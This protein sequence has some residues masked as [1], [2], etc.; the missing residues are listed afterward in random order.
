MVGAASAGSSAA[1]AW[2][3]VVGL[4]TTLSAAIVGA[5]IQRQIG[6]RRNAHEATLAAQA[7]AH[8]LTAEHARRIF[9]QRARTYI[10]LVRYAQAELTRLNS[11]LE[12]EMT[13]L[14]AQHHEGGMEM[15]EG[16]IGELWA[17][18]QVFGTEPVRQ[19]QTKMIE[20]RSDA[21]FALQAFRLSKRANPRALTIPD[22]DD[23]VRTQEA[24]SLAVRQLLD[25]TR[26]E[27]QAH[28]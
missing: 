6:D 7:Q 5:R 2:V 19:A 9:E 12:T 23:C 13:G 11:A 10:S 20:A 28:L 4:F 26:D 14:G 17:E 1:T 24:F 3:A 27:I 18:I 21:W 15:D 25:A 22:P 16:R 8:E